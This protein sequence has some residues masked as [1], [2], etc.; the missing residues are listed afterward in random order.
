[1][2]SRAPGQ[3]HRVP[4]G[5]RGSKPAALLGGEREPDTGDLTPDGCRPLPRG[6]PASCGQMPSSLART[7]TSPASVQT[8]AGPARLCT[9]QA[10][11]RARRYLQG[12]AGLW[13]RQQPLL[14]GVQPVPQGEELL[15]HLQ[16]L[17]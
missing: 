7:K 6:L 5:P 12:R 2:V 15:L 17:L 4:P 1:M 3:W 10:H 13:Q 8:W 9:A 11:P 14:Y 16:S